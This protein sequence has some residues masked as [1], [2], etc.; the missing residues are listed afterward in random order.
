MEDTLTG[1][2]NNSNNDIDHVSFKEPE[3]IVIQHNPETDDDVVD[4]TT[5]NV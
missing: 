5:Y 2:G 1:L 3:K 4:P